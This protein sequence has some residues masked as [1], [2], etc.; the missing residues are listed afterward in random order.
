LHQ[1]VNPGANVIA[2]MQDHETFD[3]AAFLA[4]VDGDVELMQELVSLFLDDCP[5]RMTCLREALDCGDSE[6]LAKAAHNL[7]GAVGNL[8]ASRSF[9]TVQ[10]LETAARDG[11]LQHA[12]TAYTAL[13]QEIAHLRTELA[14]LSRT[15]A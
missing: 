5:Q 1:E 15:Q 3:R 9:K 10:R 8:C 13:E 6:A 4:R 2:P 14:S 7:K 11:D 12:A